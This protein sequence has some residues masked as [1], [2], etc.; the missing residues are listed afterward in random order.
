MYFHRSSSHHPRRLRE[1]AHTGPQG[2]G[3]VVLLLDPFTDVRRRC[4]EVALQASLVCLRDRLVAGQ[5]V[6]AWRGGRLVE[7]GRDSCAHNK[8]P[9][10]FAVPRRRGSS[11][12]LSPLGCSQG[13]KDIRAQRRE[14][15][16]A[17]TSGGT[18]SGGAESRPHQVRKLSSL[19]AFCL[20]S[21]LDATAWSWLG[22]GRYFYGVWYRVAMSGSILF[23]FRGAVDLIARIAA[24]FPWHDALG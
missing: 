17:E 4:A 22:L 1:R 11:L 6:G 20:R 24:G 2:D 14:G 10:H 7:C 15:G 5:A 16:R 19:T 13:L 18:G 12:R 8:P 9:R 3:T 23:F 21:S